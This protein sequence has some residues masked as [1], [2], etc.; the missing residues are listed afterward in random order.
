MYPPARALVLL[1]LALLL[2]GRLGRA[3]LLLL[4]LLLGRCRRRTGS[5]PGTDRLRR[6]HRVVARREEPERE[7][8]AVAR[9]VSFIECRR[10]APRDA[11]DRDH[12]RAQPRDRRP[13]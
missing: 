13:R 3:M 5:R 11:A 9:V 6:T 7:I 10:A 1:L 12:V 8:R 2:L 4:A